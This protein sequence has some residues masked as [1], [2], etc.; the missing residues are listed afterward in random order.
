MGHRGSLQFWHKRRAHGR[1][2]RVRSAP[3]NMK[4]PI[5]S[6]LVAYKV[7]MGHVNMIDDSEAPSK[8]QEVST[9]CTFLEFPKIEIYG[10]RFYS[11]D[12]NGYRKAVAEI[13]SKEIMTKLKQKPKQDESKLNSM[14]ENLKDYTDITALLIA[15]P[16]GMSVEQHHPL[17][18][19]S[20]IGGTVDDKF[21][22][23]SSKIGKEV[24]ATEMIKNGEYVDIA[25]VTVGKGWQGVIKRFGVAR[26]SHKAT[27]KIRHVGTLGPF[28]PGKVLFTVPQ[29]GQMGFNYRTE[30]NKRVLKMGTSL[31]AP[32]MNPKAGFKNY[33]N[34]KNDYIIVSGSV[35]GPSKRL[36]RIRKS[37][38]RNYKGI[39]EPKLDFV[40]T[41]NN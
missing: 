1:L 35:P 16:K 31:D 19:E 30:A 41:M 36:V 17:K 38:T 18:F 13:H 6:N 11:K 20:S 7:G 26:L 22:F 23:I 3:Q 9:S 32:K 25:S 29:A 5:L 27:N 34:I 39:K 12:I 37:S 28:T 15:Y 33:G 2:P 8:N 24:K 14:K 21:N 40:S 4:E 10:A